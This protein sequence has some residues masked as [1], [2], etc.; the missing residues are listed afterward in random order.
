MLSS[1]RPADSYV[2]LVLPTGR[3]VLVE[4]D[5]GSDCLILDTPF[6]AE[7]GLEAGGPGV[8][9]R[10]GVDETGHTYVRHDAVL[11]GS[12]HLAAAPQTAQDGPR[13]IFQEIIHDGL[14]GEP[15]EC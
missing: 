11:P 13:V 1:P 8:S 6:M 4:G 3:T 10:E 7:C 12:V 15:R 9:A 5:T 14:S 2:R